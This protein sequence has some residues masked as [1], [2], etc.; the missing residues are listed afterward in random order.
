[1]SKAQREKGARYER[2]IATRLR[3]V[4]GP[5]IHRG[6]Q[7]RGG[8]EAG[9]ITGTDMPEWL[10]LECHH[11]NSST[12][13]AKLRQA[14][15]DRPATDVLRAAVVKRHGGDELVAMRWDDFIRLVALLA[16]SKRPGA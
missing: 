3:D 5:D 15:S 7:W 10:H 13:F 2:D 6:I 11:G 8:S 1:M 16:E 4:F 9:D 14:E 12:P